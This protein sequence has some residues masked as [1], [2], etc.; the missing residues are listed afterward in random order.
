MTNV[1][2]DIKGT[3]AQ[4]RRI[5]RAV[6]HPLGHRPLHASRVAMRDWSRL[7]EHAAAT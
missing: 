2:I 4:I 7:G 6:F 1:T 5:S 3:A